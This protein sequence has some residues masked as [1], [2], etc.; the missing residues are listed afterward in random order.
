MSNITKEQRNKDLQKDFVTL[1]KK[2]PEWKSSFVVEK[3]AKKYY[4]SIDWAYK[5]I[6]TIKQCA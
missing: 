5:I 4:L 3:L 6:A 1:S 2:H